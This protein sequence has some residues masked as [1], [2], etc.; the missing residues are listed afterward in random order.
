MVCSETF[1]SEAPPRERTSPRAR[2]HAR[3]AQVKGT[4]SSSF[5]VYG[6]CRNR[7]SLVPSVRE[8]AVRRMGKEGRYAF[9]S[10]RDDRI[11][12][13]AAGLCEIRRG[14]HAVLETWALHR[15]SPWTGGRRR[16]SRVRAIESTHGRGLRGTRGREVR[17][18]VR[19]TSNGLDDVRHWPRRPLQ[20]HGASLRAAS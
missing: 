18:A 6:V 14:A 16:S 5:S 3:S 20:R 4:P 10:E 13:A 19:R 17:T 7:S 12:H 1:S 15:A 11:E 8:R 2:T 9:S